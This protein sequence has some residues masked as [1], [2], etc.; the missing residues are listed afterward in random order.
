MEIVESENGVEF[1]GDWAAENTFLAENRYIGISKEGIESYSAEWLEINSEEIKRLIAKIGENMH[2][3][4]SAQLSVE[5][6]VVV[7]YVHSAIA[8][9][10]VR[11]LPLAARPLIRMSEKSFSRKML[12]RFFVRSGSIVHLMFYPY[13][14]FGRHFHRLHT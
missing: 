9:G 13:L 10:L 1:K 14:R 4:R 12:W 6:G 5:N 7:G 8:E 3:R 2:L 11:R